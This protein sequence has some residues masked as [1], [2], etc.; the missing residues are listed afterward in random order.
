M[1]AS[2]ADVGEGRGGVIS[3]LLER[4][5]SSHHVLAGANALLIQPH[6]LLPRRAVRLLQ[7]RRQRVR[8]E[9]GEARH[10][11]CTTIRPGT[12][13]AARCRPPR[14][15]SASEHC[16]PSAAISSCFFLTSACKGLC[17]CVC[18]CQP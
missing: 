14:R 5:L 7:P 12:Q 11:C 9:A 18:V 4:P 16:L 3:A 15:T 1:P 8:G 6:V 2:C 17:V 10:S 13:L